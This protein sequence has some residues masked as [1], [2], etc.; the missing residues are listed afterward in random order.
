MTI[1]SIVCL[2]F[3]QIVTFTAAA[4]AHAE[5][6]LVLEDCG[7][8]HI[9]EYQQITSKGMAHKEMVTCIE[10][11]ENHRPMS[12]N[13]IPECSDCHARFPHK[14]VVDCASCHERK[15]NCKACHLV[16]QPLAQTDGKTALTHCMV[17]HPE[18]YELLK[19]N[20]TKHHELSCAFCHDEHRKIQNCS[21]CHDL[22]HSEGTHKLF[23]C[24]DCHGIAH[25]L[26]EMPKN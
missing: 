24:L 9:K 26:S 1:N 15:E 4:T 25:D 5:T 21:E 11:H 8:C 17:C 12:E 19:T 13:N 2:I 3:M 10:C 22:P 20:T 7:K 6:S 14:Y 16:H 23:K 18:V